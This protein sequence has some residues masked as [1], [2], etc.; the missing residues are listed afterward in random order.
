MPIVV[1]VK[2]KPRYTLTGTIREPI[3]I[4]DRVLCVSRPVRPHQRSHKLIDWAHT[5]E[6]LND[7]ALG[8]P[9]PSALLTRGANTMKTDGK[10]IVDDPHA[11]KVELRASRRLIHLVALSTALGR[12][13]WGLEELGQFRPPTDPP[14]LQ[15]P[16]RKARRKAFA[17]ARKR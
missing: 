6:Y 4:R 3:G 12:P 10:P 16:N 2:V 14:K 15:K 5:L 7:R 9:V 13:A 17:H 1:T 11:V 8:Y